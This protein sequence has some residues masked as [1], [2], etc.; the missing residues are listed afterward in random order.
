MSEL[1]RCVVVDPADPQSGRPAAVV[2]LHG[3]GATGHDFEPI[4]P[5]L[6]LPWVRFVFPHAPQRPV[7]IN[8]GMVMPSWYDI[9]HLGA[10]GQNES[11]IAETSSNVEALIARERESV[12]AER[13]VLAGFSQGGAIALWVGLR[14]AERLAGLMILSS[15]EMF[16]DRRQERSPENRSTPILFGH[17]L[18]DPMVP[19]DRGRAA[20][21]GAASRERDTRWLEYPMGHEVCPAEIDDIAAWLRERLPASPELAVF[22][23]E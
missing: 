8:G 1:L 10:G 7:T 14:H 21:E 17:G 13:I 18:H 11:H 22:D 16:P 20:Y 15:Y 4:V 9:T 2:W 6:G 12:A 19:V 3:L 23:S 5:H